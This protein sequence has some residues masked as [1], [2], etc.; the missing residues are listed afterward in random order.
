MQ[1]CALTAASGLSDIKDW[2]VR[3]PSVLQRCSGEC[4]ILPLEC[5]TAVFPQ[6]AHFVAALAD[7][8]VD[9][10]E[11]RHG[12]FGRRFTVAGSL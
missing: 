6:K 10:G 4:R 2:G 12:K 1:R 9:A 7:D 8:E 11:S 5:P 3:H